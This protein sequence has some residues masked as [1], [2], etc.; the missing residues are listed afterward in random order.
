MFL[1]ASTSHDDGESSTGAIFVVR[2]VGSEE[3]AR[4]LGVGTSGR[5]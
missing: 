4:S 3:L 5:S 2:C 1:S